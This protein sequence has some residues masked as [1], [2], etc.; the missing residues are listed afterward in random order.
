MSTQ[1]KDFTRWNIIHQIW[2]LAWPTMLSIFFYSLYNI[3]DTYWV[4]RISADA[5]AA[6]WISQIAIY[7]MLALSMG[8]SIWSSVLVSMNLW[9]KNFKEAQR[10]L[11]QSFILAAIIG[12]FFTI[13]ALVFQDPLLKYSWA[14][15][16]ILPLAK[17]YYVIYATG[18][19]LTFILI[20]ITF[21]FN[22]EGDTFTLTKI[23]AFTTILNIILD[24]IFIFWKFGFPALW[25]E[26]AA[27]ATILCQTVFIALAMRILASPERW[28][29]FSFK[30]ISVKWESVKKVCNIG[31]PASLTQVI[32]PVWIAFITYMIGM[33]YFEPG[34]TAFNLVFR[35]EFFAYLP[36]IGFW[37]ALLSMIWQNVWAG[38]MQRANEIYKKW[39]TLWFVSSIVLGVLFII[40]GKYI[41]WAF[42]QDPVVIQYSVKYLMIVAGTYG[43][44]AVWLMSAQVFQAMWKSWPGFWLGVIKYI[45]FMFPMIYICITFTDLSIYYIWWIVWLS[46]ILIATVAYF[47]VSSH[48]KI[49]KITS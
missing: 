25:L 20:N 22:S 18:S 14:Y 5:I 45:L 30:N 32:N 38:N 40:W 33:K 47:W 37:M 24:P 2:S 3:V 12:L 36:A 17:Q 6:V 19:I 4:W 15:W 44:L 46:N 41:I 11:G 42:T 34:A 8:I 49:K 26:W 21:A 13:V 16:D 7:M 1:I 29:Y 10:V 39:L 48:L 28:L 23:F 9:S 43:F 27:W 31:I 35:L